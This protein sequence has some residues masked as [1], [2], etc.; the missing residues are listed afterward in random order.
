MKMLLFISIFSLLFP[1]FT[2]GQNVNDYSGEWILDKEKSNLAQ[3]SQIASM[4]MTVEQTRNEIIVTT[5]TEF[6]PFPTPVRQNSNEAKG[7]SFGL[8]DIKREYVGDGTYKYRLD[9]EERIVEV[10]VENMSQKTTVK[11][12]A[13]FENG[14]L[15][16]QSIRVFRGSG[17]EFILK[18]VETWELR[19]NGKSLNI[20]REGEF[21]NSGKQ[22]IEL[23]FTRK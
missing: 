2:F 1:I 16:L 11:L 8:Y 4:M 15:K 12:K 10:E 23:F 6:P 5:T 3:L 17:G 7:T 20:T 19:D 14:L 13:F 21:R 9:G 22:K 18:A